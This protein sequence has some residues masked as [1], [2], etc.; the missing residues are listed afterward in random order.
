MKQNIIFKSVQF[1]SPNI[2]SVFTKLL[3]FGILT[4]S[5]LNNRFGLIE[6]WLNAL[7]EIPFYGINF[8]SNAILGI[9][10]VNNVRVITQSFTLLTCSNLIFI[11]AENH[12][13]L[14]IQGQHYGKLRTL[15]ITKAFI[16]YIQLNKHFQI[17]L[18]SLMHSAYISVSA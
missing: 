6:S 2:Q 11:Q 9:L 15:R 17:K 13:I 1:V 3:S 18:P 14:N 4:S 5:C 8:F 12:T 10:A 7:Q 16:I